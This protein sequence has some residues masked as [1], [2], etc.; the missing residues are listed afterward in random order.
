[1][2]PAI[3][4]HGDTCC[5]STGAEMQDFSLPTQ[6]PPQLQLATSEFSF[7]C[8][9]TAS[10][11]QHTWSRADF[12]QKAKRIR[13]SCPLGWDPLRSAT[14]DYGQARLAADC[15]LTNAISTSSLNSSSSTFASKPG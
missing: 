6:A 15:S 10:P 9:T 11:V 5:L 12:T 7:D 2:W 13:L 8:P 4:R 1:M 3:A 14:A